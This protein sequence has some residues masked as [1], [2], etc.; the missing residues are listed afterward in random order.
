[1]FAPRLGVKI[2]WGKYMSNNHGVASTSPSRR[3]VVKG[4][5]WAVPAVVVA[6]AAPAMA[7]SPGIITFT[8]NACKLP[9]NSQSIFKGYV[10][11]LKGNNVTGPMPFDAVVIIDSIT[12]AN[13]PDLGAYKVVVPNPAGSCSCGTACASGENADHIVCVPDGTTNLQILIYTSANVTGNSANDMVT[14]TYRVFDCNG[15]STC[16]SASSGVTTGSIGNTPPVQG[17]C[18]IPGAQDNIPA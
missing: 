13:T 16:P 8:G 17:P 12:V 3:T 2:E 15:G 14:I 11:E 18:P 7:A 10:F 1:M 9:G 6:G 5:A 4:A